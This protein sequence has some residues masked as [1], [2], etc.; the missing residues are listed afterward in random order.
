[1]GAAGLPYRPVRRLPW[2]VPVNNLLRFSH[3]VMLIGTGRRAP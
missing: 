3:D 2:P 1:V